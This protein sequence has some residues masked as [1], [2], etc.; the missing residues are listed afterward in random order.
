MLRAASVMSIVPPRSTLPSGVST[1][2][3][4]AVGIRSAHPSSGRPNQALPTWVF[5]DG[6]LARKLSVVARNVVGQLP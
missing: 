3:L 5:A 1:L 2:T 4:V 6:P